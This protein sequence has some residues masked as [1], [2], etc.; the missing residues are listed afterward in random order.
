MDYMTAKEAAVK[1]GVSDRQVQRLIAGGRIAHCRKHGNSWLIPADGKKP[2]DPR[3]A[4]KQPQAQI[5]FTL[6]RQCPVLV[7]TTLYRAPGG[8]D[9]AAE[10]LADD[11]AAQKLFTAQLAYF[12]GET[13]KAARLAEALLAESDAPDVRLGCGFVLCLSAMYTGGTDAWTNAYAMIQRIPCQNHADAALRDFLLASVDSGLYDKS[14]FPIWFQQ[15]DFCPLPGDCFPLARM[16]YLKYL[17][18]DRGDPS[19]SVMC[20][21]L[22]S[23]CRLEGALL[24]EIYCRLLT[25]IGFHDRGNNGRAAELI[26]AAIALA[27]PDR[28]YAP[29]AEERGE[30]GVLLDER[31][32][33][34][35][36]DA[37]RAVREL[38]KRLMTGW[39]ALQETLKGRTYAVDLTP[40]EHHA[41]KLAAKGLTNAEIAERM[42]IS[43][44][45]V[46][47]Y[48]A[49]AVGKTGAENRAALAEEGTGDT[50]PQL[51]ANFSS[52]PKKR[53]ALPLKLAEGDQL[54]INGVAIETVL[55]PKGNPLISAG[56]LATAAALSGSA[57]AS[58]RVEIPVKK[59]GELA[60]EAALKDILV[61]SD[62]RFVS[63]SAQGA[64]G[65]ALTGV[66]GEQEG[67][68]DAEYAL[69][70]AIRK[71]MNNPDYKWWNVLSHIYEVL[72]SPNANAFDLLSQDWSIPAETIKELMGIEGTGASLEIWLNARNGEDE[73]R[74][75]ASLDFPSQESDPTL[76]GVVGEQEELGLSNAD[77]ALLDAVRKGMNNPNYSWQDL[78]DYVTLVMDNEGDAYN[79]MAEHWG[80][81]AETIKELMGDDN[82]E[83]FLDAWTS[84]RD[85]AMKADMLGEFM[86][87]RENIQAHLNINSQAFTIGVNGQ[88]FTIG[89]NGVSAGT[90]APTVWQ[91]DLTPPPYHDPSYDKVGE[92]NASGICQHGRPLGRCEIPPCAPG[93]PQ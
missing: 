10:S 53:T 12:R 29:L 72:R 8:G 89:V 75:R 64:G 33:L 77:Y 25:A 22:I 71:G 14:S 65:V 31:L 3:K 13:D 45:S 57:D 73:E 7:M 15:G 67:L 92:A 4:R 44:N 26:D 35:D 43:V 37:V 34:A 93:N 21:P 9:L 76:A 42:G 23:Q 17:L 91:D 79:M 50:A 81:P 52:N 36:K 63:Y 19:I 18:L 58:G 2:P 24:S 48:I 20:G 30:L 54:S 78:L 16:L 83:A 74:V 60:E 11:P 49:E 88:T 61:S 32:A 59:M 39:S 1:W 70:L 41:A 27:L 69:L 46:K 86:K 82:T 62:G 66:V 51:T 40:R 47:R 84:D 5:A 38:Q 68:S 87:D 56:A 55:G 6:P 80:I 28:L 85:A 90:L